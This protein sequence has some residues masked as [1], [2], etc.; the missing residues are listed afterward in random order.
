LW[1][2]KY[3]DSKEQRDEETHLF[4]V[5]TKTKQKKYTPETWNKGSI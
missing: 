2:Q 4:G 5:D 3:Q 1:C